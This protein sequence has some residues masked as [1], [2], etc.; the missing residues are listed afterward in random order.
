[1][2][3]NTTIAQLDAAWKRLRQRWEDTKA[4]WN[5]PVQRHFD[6]EYWTPLES[7]TQTTL[8]EMERL[9]ETIAK[10]RRNVK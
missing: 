7:Q 9:T 6:K 2:G 10:A 8:Q 5:D 4:V 3:M 1:A